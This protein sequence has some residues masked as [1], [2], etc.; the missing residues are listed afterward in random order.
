MK[1]VNICCIIIETNCGGVKGMENEYET[2]S[3]KP[4]ANINHTDEKEEHKKINYKAVSCIMMALVIAVGIANLVMSIKTY[5]KYDELK[6]NSQFYFQT[7][8]QAVN[9]SSGIIIEPASNIQS[10]NSETT[11]LHIEITTNATVKQNNVASNN[12]QTVNSTTT[13]TAA[14]TVKSETGNKSLININTA[15]KEELTALNGIGDS[16]AQAIIDYRNENGYFSS[17]DELMN[18]SGI[19]EKTFAKNKDLITVD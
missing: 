8:N 13:T 17:I 12:S 2:F 1:Y 10:N 16:K 15:T 6:V 7:D 19:G 3:N 14:T 5:K 9:S 11:V 18:V 4:Y